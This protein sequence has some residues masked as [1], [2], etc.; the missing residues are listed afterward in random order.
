LRGGVGLYLKYSQNLAL[1]LIA[2]SVAMARCCRAA[3]GILPKAFLTVTKPLPSLRAVY[4]L[5]VLPSHLNCR[6][7]GS[8]V[9][10]PK[11]LL[12]HEMLVFS[13]WASDLITSGEA[14]MLLSLIRPPGILVC[15]QERHQSE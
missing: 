12:L 13:P 8:T 14:N 10:V 6:R 11:R 3:F 15:L 7:K 2:A 9:Q 5:D 1:F 4:E